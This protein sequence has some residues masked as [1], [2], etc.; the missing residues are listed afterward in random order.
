MYKRQ[1]SHFSWN[2]TTFL[3]IVFLALAGVIWWLARHRARFGG[4]TGYAIDPV[5]AMQVRI[6]DAPATARHDGVYFYFCSDRCRD[7]FDADPHRHG[8]VSESMHDGA[9]ES[10]TDPVCSMTVDPAT[11]ADHRYPGGVDYWFCST[12]CATRF[13][14]DPSRFIGPDRVTE[15]MRVGP[16]SLTLRETPVQPTSIDPICAMSVPQDSR[17]VSR[18]LD[19]SEVWFC[20]S[21]CADT[22][23]ALSASERFAAL[24]KSQGVAP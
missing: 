5:C 1:S 10:A 11:S 2:Y 8:V 15:P 4:G 16:V 21:G 13:D 24:Q 19:D 3:N 23:E 14:D 20:S 9:V 6:A 17:A 22:F 18:F 7:R 12:D